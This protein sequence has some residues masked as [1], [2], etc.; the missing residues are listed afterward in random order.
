MSLN[1]NIKQVKGNL[2]RL[3][4]KNLTDLVR[5]LRNNKDNEVRLFIFKTGSESF[6][7]L[8]FSHIHISNSFLTFHFLLRQIILLNALKR[9]NR[10]CESTI[11]A[12]NVMQ[13][14]N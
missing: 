7:L 11:L 8:F 2:Q 6:F 1:L 9:L 14:Q 4:D 5:G 3:F 13:S 10:N 12:S